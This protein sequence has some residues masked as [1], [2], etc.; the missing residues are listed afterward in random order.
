M[1]MKRIFKR[2][3]NG[4]AGGMMLPVQ[5]MYRIQSAFFGRERACVAVGQ[6]VAKWPGVGGEYLRRIVLRRILNRVGRDVVVSFGSVLTKPMAELDDGVY[7]GAY[8]LLGDVRMG[9]NTL[10]ADHVCIPSGSGQHQFDR[11][12]VPIRDQAGE[13]RTVRIGEDVWIGSHCVILADVGNHCVVGAGSVVTHPVP[14]YQVVAGNPARIL[15]DRRS[16][17]VEPPPK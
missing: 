11:L 3:A 17:P 15:R 4:L 12:D 16:G 9:K 5:A 13:F 14:D 6:R 7:I 1:A 8:C 2:I 10:I